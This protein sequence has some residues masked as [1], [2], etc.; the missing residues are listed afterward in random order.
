MR[1]NWG[2][3]V[4]ADRS[5][6]L[7]IGAIPM[8]WH[9]INNDKTSFSF[10]LSI[11]F[12]TLLTFHHTT[13]PPMLCCVMSAERKEEHCV[14]K[15]YSCKLKNWTGTSIYGAT[16]PIYINAWKHVFF[17]FSGT[18]KKRNREETKSQPDHQQKLSERQ[19]ISRYHN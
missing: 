12:S 2:Q 14:E 7:V 3:K 11:K 5:I 19:Q 4:G 6:Q 8:Y 16:A 9:Q 17:F 1:L 13:H 18:R 10:F 15:V